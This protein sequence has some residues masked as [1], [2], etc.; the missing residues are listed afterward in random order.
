MARQAVGPGQLGG[1]ICRA[2]GGTC[3][4]VYVWASMHVR[5]CSSLTAHDAL[6]LLLGT[7]LKFVYIEA[8]VS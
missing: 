2:S 5:S 6:P 7:A 1:A 3:G 4:L 8:H